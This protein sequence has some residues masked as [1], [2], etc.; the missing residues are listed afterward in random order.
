MFTILTKILLF[1]VFVAVISAS[2]TFIQ[3]LVSSYLVTNSFFAVASYLGFMDGL[4]LFLT[5]IVAGFGAK[6]ILAFVR[7]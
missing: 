2:I 3:N 6:Q 1:T 5:I 4:S 7:S